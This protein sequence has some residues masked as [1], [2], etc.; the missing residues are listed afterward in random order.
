MM[1]T[2]ALNPSFVE[3]LNYLQLGKGNLELEMKVR[4]A[5]DN[6]FVNAVDDTSE[7]SNN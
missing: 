3:N 1:K 4:K 5:I 2:W 6:N 7:L